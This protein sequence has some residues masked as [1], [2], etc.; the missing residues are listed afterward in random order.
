MA[1][2]VDL[3]VSVNGDAAGHIAVF[4][5][6]DA[7]TVTT[8]IIF[9]V[10]F[11][12]DGGAAGNMDFTGHV[13]TLVAA[14]YGVIV[15]IL[16]TIA[17]FGLQRAAAGDGHIAVGDMQGRAA[18]GENLVVSLQCDVR[19]GAAHVDGVACAADVDILNGDICRCIV[20]GGYGD[21]AVRCLRAVALLDDRSIIRNV[22]AASLGHRLAAVSGADGN[23]AVL[24]IPFRRKRGHRQVHD[25]QQRDDRGNQSSHFHWMYVLLSRPDP[26]PSGRQ[27]GI[28]SGYPIVNFPKAIRCIHQ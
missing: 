22:C 5:G 1:E 20:R 12:G 25:Q 21:G 24:Q 27:S 15:F 18:F 4:A 13:F 9:L 26:Y 17:D 2:G 11:R 14:D 3:C 16:C 10:I 28:A 19:A 8:E 7:R 6:T 23:V